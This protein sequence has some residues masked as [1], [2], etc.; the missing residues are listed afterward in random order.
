MCSLSLDSLTIQSSN[1][2]HPSGFRPPSSILG[3]IVKR[4][5]HSTY[6]MFSLWDLIWHFVTQCAIRTKGLISWFP[7]GVQGPFYSTRDFYKVIQQSY[8]PTIKRSTMEKYAICRRDYSAKKSYFFTIFIY[9]RSFFEGW[10]HY[11]LAY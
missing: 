2:N 11:F 1:Q 6:L 7:N 4:E 8:E 5:L 3:S 9:V 10:H